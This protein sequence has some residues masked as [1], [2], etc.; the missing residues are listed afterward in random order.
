[1]VRNVTA[2]FSFDFDRCLGVG[3]RVDPI[4]SHPI[5]K[6]RSHFFEKLKESF[7]K[8]MFNKLIF[9]HF[10]VFRDIDFGSYLRDLIQWNLY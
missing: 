6:V 3:V 8:T 2:Q 5:A 9:K 7:L 1:M 4:H 10:R